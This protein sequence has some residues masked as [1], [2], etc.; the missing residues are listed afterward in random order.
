M[1]IHSEKDSTVWKLYTQ[2]IIASSLTRPWYEW[3]SEISLRVD[4]DMVSLYTWTGSFVIAYVPNTLTMPIVNPDLKALDRWRPYG[5][6]TC[7]QI[8]PNPVLSNLWDLE[9]G[10]EDRDLLKCVWTYCGNYLTSF[11]K[12]A[13]TSAP[14]HASYP[15]PLPQP[16]ALAVQISPD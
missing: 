12:A 2:T 6:N 9:S 16:P 3:V 8:L 1:G 7:S 4:N 10:V 5:E 11:P 15:I 13:C 14:P